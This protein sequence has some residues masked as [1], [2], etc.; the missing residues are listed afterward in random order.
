MAKTSGHVVFNKSSHSEMFNIENIFVFLSEINNKLGDIIPR[1]TSIEERLDSFDGVN[2][3]LCQLKSNTSE[4]LA[5]IR[6]CSSG[7]V[8]A[9]SEFSNSDISDCP[10]EESK[11]VD[12]NKAW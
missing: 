12:R 7:S 4:I 9:V 6:S 5:E 1:V 10:P 2:N 3:E 8:S 11:S